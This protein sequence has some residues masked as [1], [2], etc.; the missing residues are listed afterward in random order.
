MPAP[1]DR[2]PDA[3]IFRVG[4]FQGPS[5]QQ[6]PGLIGGYINK[7]FG[8]VLGCQRV[9]T[10]PPLGSVL[11]HFAFALERTRDAVPMTLLYP[12]T[13]P[14]DGQ[15]RFDWYPATF[16]RQAKTWTVSDEPAADHNAI[17]N[18]QS[19]LFG[20]LK[21]DP[22]AAADFDDG[23]GAGTLSF[24]PPAKQPPEAAAAKVEAVK[25]RK[26]S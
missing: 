23:F 8:P 14:L 15:P 17:S 4:Y 19:V 24:A 5:L 21:E 20:W 13:H 3:V 26:G 12:K 7:H 18:Q 11:G 10:A 6:D 1:R 2:A 25:S 16:D 22:T 9:A